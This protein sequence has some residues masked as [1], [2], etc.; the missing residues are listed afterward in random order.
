MRFAVGPR[1]RNGRSPSDRRGSENERLFGSMTLE[2]HEIV[3]F[4]GVED[5]PARP[6]RLVSPPRD[7]VARTEGIEQRLVVL[8]EVQMGM[9]TPIGVALK[10]HQRL[11]VQRGPPVVAEEDVVRPHRHRRRLAAAGDDLDRAEVRTQAT[12]AFGDHRGVQRGLEVVDDDS[13]VGAATQAEFDEDLQRRDDAAECVRRRGRWEDERQAPPR[14][15]IDDHRVA[16]DHTLFHGRPAGELDARLDQGLAHRWRQGA[17]GEFPQGHQTPAD[18]RALAS[19][20]GRVRT[21]TA[22]GDS[23]WVSVAR[24]DLYSRAS[25]IPMIMKII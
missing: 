6:G 8:D 19:L 24:R 23:R 12:R 20:A 5:A 16:V 22:A 1:A 4:T 10:I 25:I 13:Q 21:C 17:L 11:Q 3:K 15:G 14:L 9:V 7:H 18:R 2:L